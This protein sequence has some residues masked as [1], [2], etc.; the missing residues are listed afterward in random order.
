MMSAS[1]SER[2]SDA[3]NWSD[4]PMSIGESD[5]LFSFLPVDAWFWRSAMP[6]RLVWRCWIA[7]CDNEMSETRPVIAV[8]FPGS[9]RQCSRSRTSTPHHAQERLEHRVERRD[10]LRRSLVRLLELDHVRHLFVG[11]DPRL[12]IPGSIEAL[13]RLLLDVVAGLH[14][15]GGHTELDDHRVVGG[16]GARG[17][18]RHVTEPDGDA[19]VE[20][21]VGGDAGGD[22]ARVAGDER[23]ERERGGVGAGEEGAAADP[24]APDG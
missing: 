12:S 4:W 14:V 5:G 18:P 3:R 23:R 6:P 20:R 24:V 15:L 2:A 11:V 8:P 9:R 13:H 19:G 17:G 7:F 10:E 1:W 21:P 16:V 22:R